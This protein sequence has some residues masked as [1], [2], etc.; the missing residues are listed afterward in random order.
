[1]ATSYTVSYN[2]P[3]PIGVS[4]DLTN[5][6]LNFTEYQSSTPLTYYL[7]YILVLL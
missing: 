7:I 1:M 2:P 4:M 6:V 5:G 3:N